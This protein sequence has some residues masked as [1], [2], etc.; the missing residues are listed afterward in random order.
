MAIAAT[1]VWEMRDTGSNTNGGFYKSDAGTTDYSQQDSAQLALTDIASDGA[2][3]GIS[4]ATGGFTA[5]MVGN[6]IYITGGDGFTTGWYEITA[7]ADTNN[8]TIDRSAGASKTGGTGNV[9]GAVA[10]PLDSMLE[11]FTAGNILYIKSGTYTFTENIDVAKDGSIAAPMQVWGYNTTRGD[12]PTG[13]NRPLFA[14]G[15][16]KFAVDDYWKIGHIR[17]TSTS[18]SS[19]FRADSNGLMI[20]LKAQHTSDIGA[21]LISALVSTVFVIGCEATS[22]NATSNALG[23]SLGLDSSADGNYCH[24]LGS[25]STEG[26]RISADCSLSFNTLDTCS[27]GINANGNNAMIKN[28]TIYNCTTGIGTTSGQ[29]TILNNDINSCTTG[30]SGGASTEILDYNNFHNNGTD[31]SGVSK[32]ANATA[33]AP[34]Y[35]DAANGDFSN[36]LSTDNAAPIYKFG[37]NSNIMKQG[38]HQDTGTAEVCYSCVT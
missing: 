11:T 5:A 18:S 16:Y 37:S 23:I 7:H 17:A 10:L 9:G 30:I 22:P 13:T 35:A 2:G 3:T 31:V 38:A 20:N 27:Q 21:P 8:I 4:S 28:N 36:V 25:G 6:G 12:A 32:G 34:S 26:I 1:A 19:L 24:D 15:S 29:I 14:M 33:V